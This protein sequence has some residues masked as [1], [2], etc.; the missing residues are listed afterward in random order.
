LNTHSVNA[1]TYRSGSALSTKNTQKIACYFIL[2]APPK[3]KSRAAPFSDA[4]RL[5]FLIAGEY[6]LIFFFIFL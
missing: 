4:V 2:L 3:L 5:Y 6:F 1:G